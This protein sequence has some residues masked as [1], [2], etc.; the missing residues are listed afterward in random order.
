[1]HHIRFLLVGDEI[2]SFVFGQAGFYVSEDLSMLAIGVELLAGMGGRAC[3]TLAEIW[4]WG[5]EGLVAV[6]L[7]LVTH[8]CGAPRAVKRAG[9]SCAL[10]AGQ[11]WHLALYG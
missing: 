3:G 10:S 1:V 8:F 11:A 9:Q 7:S 5:M 6:W 4:I 2:A